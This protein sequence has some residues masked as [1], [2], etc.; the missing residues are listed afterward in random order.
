MLLV[1]VT[2]GLKLVATSGGYG[3][4]LYDD[5]LAEKIVGL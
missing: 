5:G 4:S 1:A 3:G 2:G